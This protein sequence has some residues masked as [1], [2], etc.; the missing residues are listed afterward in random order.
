M[1]TLFL[2]LTIIVLECVLSIDNA[3]ALAAMVKHLPINDRKKALR[4]G[5]IGAYVFRGIALIFAAWLIQF[6]FLK[7][8]G[9]AY[10]IYL[11]YDFFSGED[12]EDQKQPIIMSFWKTVA[13][14]EVMD[15]VFSID[16]ILAVVAMTTNMWA[17]I[18]GVLVGITAMRF[19]AGIFSDLLE[20]YPEL[21]SYAFIVIGMLGMKLVLGF[22]FGFFGLH[23]LESAIES[24]TASGITSGIT[25]ALFSYPFIKKL[26]KN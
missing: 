25:F 17:I 15:I 18:A 21:E 22:V 11:C 5:M 20:S 4:Y 6:A 3:A 1:A 23:M 9:G 12:S 13:I 24:H 2:I 14:V 26:C 10:L 19:A 7:L 8:L 16:N